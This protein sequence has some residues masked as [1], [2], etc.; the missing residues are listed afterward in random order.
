MDYINDKELYATTGGEATTKNDNLNVK[1]DQSH[2]DFCAQLPSIVIPNEERAHEHYID[3][4]FSGI[5]FE[6]TNPDFVH[7][8]QL[9]NVMKSIKQQGFD[10]RFHHSLHC[11]GSL[12]FFSTFCRQMRNY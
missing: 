6:A 10:P 3:A 9:Q 11:E 5:K 2:Q 1:T 7:L 8:S 4:D 12:A